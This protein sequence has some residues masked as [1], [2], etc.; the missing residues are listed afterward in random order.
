MLDCCRHRWR[1]SRGGQPDP[2]VRYQCGVPFPGLAV[3]FSLR[4]RSPETHAPASE[5]RPLSV[6]SSPPPAFPL[7]SAF[8]HA[9]LGPPPLIPQA[10]AWIGNPPDQLVGSAHL[11]SPL[12]CRMA[13]PASASQRSF[14]ALRILGFTHPSA[15]HRF[16]QFNSNTFQ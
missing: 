3:P 14:L 13:H 16:N 2:Y 10:N 6:S 8:T 15:R 5:N 4:L 9:H 1:A 7:A 12:K 11:S